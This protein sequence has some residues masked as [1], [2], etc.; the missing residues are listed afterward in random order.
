MRLLFV[1]GAGGYDEDRP[2]AEDLA[3]TLGASLD[4]P[5]LPDE[6]MSVEAWARPLRR[7]LAALGPADVVVAH[8]F[9]ASILLHVLGEDLPSAPAKG[10][11]LAMPDWGP[12]GWGVE[13][14]VHAGPEP[15]IHLSLH[16]CRDD[17]VVPFAHLALAAAALPS[18]RVHEYPSGGHQFDGRIEA[19]AA[20][21]R[22]AT[23]PS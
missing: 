20:D 23:R 17:E 12:Q 6:D 10:V 19:I 18:A 11:L 8:S 5:Q 22:V 15:A 1:H 13:D 21:V 9:G 3:D 16:H 14:Y 4:L 2:F 7:G